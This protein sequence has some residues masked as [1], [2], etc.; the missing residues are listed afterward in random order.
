[1]I[2]YKPVIGNFPETYRRISNNSLIFENSC[3]SESTNEV[4]NLESRTNTKLWSNVYMEI[5]LPSIIEHGDVVEFSEV[6]KAKPYYHNPKKMSNDL[7]GGSTD[8][9]WLILAMNNYTSIHEF[10]DF[11]QLA[12]PNEDYVTTLITS[13]ERK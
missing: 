10:K 11:T 5:Y 3:I 12:I 6:E 13:K 4:D 2:K 9:W 1:M 8:Y 7:F